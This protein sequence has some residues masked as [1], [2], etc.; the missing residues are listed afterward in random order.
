MI[1][2]D[3]LKERPLSYSSLKEFSKSPAHYINYLNKPRETT[4]ALQ[5]G[6]LLHCLLLEPQEFKNS[7]A[8]SPKFDMRKTADKEA[9]AIFQAEN[10][11]KELVSETLL[12]EVNELAEIV[13]NNE[14]WRVAVDGA[15]F[16]QKDTI[17]IY[18]LPFVRIRDIVKG[19]G[20]IDVK[21]VQSGQID[22]VVRDFYNHKYYIQAAIY[23]EPFSFYV[24]EKSAPFYNGLI[25]ASQEFLDYG[26]R[27]L[28]RLCLGFN[29]CL[30]NPE[31]FSKGYEFWYEMEGIKPIVKLPKLAINVKDN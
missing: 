2:L 6:S 20:T 9:Y 31:L 21:T 11:G 13:K 30:S 25:G 28:E 12:A 26:K 23:G 16:E 14:V 19:D 4:P 29:H 17:E 7:Y 22:D 24:V 18:D 15:S 27:E 1:T 5:F 10:E 8:V 3:T